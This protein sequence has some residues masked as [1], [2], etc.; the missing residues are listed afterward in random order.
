MV[1]VAAFSTGRRLP[2]F[3]RAG[4]PFVQVA[5]FPGRPAA[6]PV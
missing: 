2:R 1:M 4:L 5:V 6:Q 3:N